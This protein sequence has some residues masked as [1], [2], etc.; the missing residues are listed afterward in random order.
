MNGFA[1]AEGEIRLNA[2]QSL[3]G[4]RAEFRK[5]RADKSVEFQRVAQFLGSDVKHAAGQGGTELFDAEVSAD[6][7]AVRV[8]AEQN[9]EIFEFQPLF[10]ERGDEDRV[11]DFRGCAGVDEDIFVGAADQR[12]AAPRAAERSLQQRDCFIDR[13]K[14]FHYFSSSS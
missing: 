5:R 2:A 14:S 10:R 13:F 4:R 3:G 8:R 1:V 11:D 12:H 7:V 9:G 6:M